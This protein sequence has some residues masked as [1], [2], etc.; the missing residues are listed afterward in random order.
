MQACPYSC[1]I[2]A[3]ELLICML[4]ELHHSC[5]GLLKLPKDVLRLLRASS[6]HS[7]VPWALSCGYAQLK[8]V[9]WACLAWLDSAWSPV[10]DGLKWK[11]LKALQITFGRALEGHDPQPAVSAGTIVPGQSNTSRLP[12][13]AL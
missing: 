6:P 2:Y 5:N 4:L 8:R 7:Q 11:L 9:R 10:D 13:Q 12:D 3:A 1:I